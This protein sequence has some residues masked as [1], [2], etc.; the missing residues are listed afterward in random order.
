VSCETTATTWRYRKAGDKSAVA[1]PVDM[2]NVE[3]ALL[4]TD[5]I[6]HWSP[7]ATLLV[8]IAAS[9][10]PARANPS[11]IIFYRAT[12]G[13]SRMKTLYCLTYSEAH[14]NFATNPPTKSVVSKSIF[15]IK[16]YDAK[17][18]AKYD[19]MMRRVSI[20]TDV[21]WD[22]AQLQMILR[23]ADFWDNFP[24]DD[25]TLVHSEFKPGKVDQRIDLLFLAGT[26]EL[27]PCELKIRG[28]YPD[29]HGQLI[30]YVADL[31]FDPWDLA[32][33]RDAHKRFVE[34]IQDTVAVH[35]ATE[36]LDEFIDNHAAIPRT[37]TLSVRA[38][39]VI[40]DV[41]FSAA[42]KGA[43]R[44]LNERHGFK[45]E[46]ID[47]RAL[48]GDEWRADAEERWMRLDFETLSPSAGLVRGRTG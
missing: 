41:G 3:A 1:L 37:G 18:Q 4:A 10:S 39:G 30:R 42:T 36:K 45:I 29:S 32:R 43:V 8:G 21:G 23:R 34:T 27:V 33:V 9:G 6:L 16:P 26:G 12:A 48:V 24:L 31:E 19:S 11:P 5:V 7:G 47:V 15:D 13:E 38:G 25:A 35:A 2:G 14:T 17:Y 40:I 28:D 46:L 44:Y 22:E 20:T